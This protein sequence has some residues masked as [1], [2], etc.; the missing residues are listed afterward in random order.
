MRKASLAQAQERHEMGLKQPSGS[1]EMGAAAGGTG[2]SVSTTEIVRCRQAA[3]GLASKSICIRASG[4][5]PYRRFS[6]TR[7]GYPRFLAEEDFL[8]RGMIHGS[9]A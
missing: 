5:G 6:K 8:P 9:T 1:S 4:H 3:F 7:S 2:A